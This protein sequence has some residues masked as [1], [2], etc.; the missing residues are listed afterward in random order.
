[1]TADA[2]RQDC[3]NQIGVWGA[4]AERCARLDEVVHCRNCAVFIA[5]G[6]QIFERPLPPDYLQEQQ[7]LVAGEVASE[8]SG[9]ESIIA[10]RLGA[11]WFALPTAVFDG[12]TEARPIHRLPH[13]AAG[14]VQ[15]VVNIGGE[16]RLCH[17]LASLLEVAEVAAEAADERQV[18]RRLLVMHLGGEG[19]VFPA[20]EVLGLLRYRRDQLRAPPATIAEATRRRLRGSFERDGRTI[21]VLAEDALQQALGQGY[22]TPPS[23]AGEVRS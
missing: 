21:V 9:G 17:S 16:V 10:F 12:I 15:G 3:W 6:R 13:V 7:R 11:E 5:A 14:H 2:S 19:Y 1:M 23:A 4:A 20:D 8:E 22:A 18:Y